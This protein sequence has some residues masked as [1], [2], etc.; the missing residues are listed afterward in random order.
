MLNPMLKLFH[1][2]PNKIKFH[3]DVSS[4]KELTCPGEFVDDA[5]VTAMIRRFVVK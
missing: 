2:S 3:R 4:D 5:V 1:L